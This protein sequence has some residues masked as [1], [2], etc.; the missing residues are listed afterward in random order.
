M[1]TEHIGDFDILICFSLL[2]TATH[3]TAF[4]FHKPFRTFNRASFQIR[5]P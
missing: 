4:S 3:S 5:A 2:L 1:T